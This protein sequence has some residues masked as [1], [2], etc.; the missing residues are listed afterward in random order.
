VASA[1]AGPVSRLTSLT[2]DTAA[3]VERRLARK[4]SDVELRQLKAMER[5]YS[6]ANGP[7]LLMFGES[8]MVW[9]VRDEADRRHLAE[10]IRDELGGNVKLQ[11][12]VGPGYNPRIIMAMLGALPKCTSEPKVVIVPMSLLMATT[13]WLA[14][15]VLGYERVAAEM[16]EVISHGGTR[17]KRLAKPSDEEWET[18]DHIPAPS[19]IGAR[20]TMGEVRLVTSA[21][22]QTRWQQAI[23]LRHLMDSYNAERLEPES[24][25]VGLV[26]HMATTIRD[27]GL[28]SVAY[29]PPVNL[30]VGDKVLGPNAREHILRNAQLLADSYAAAAGDSGSVVNAVDQCPVNEFA[31][32]LH[33]AEAG[34]RHVAHLIAEAI[35]TYL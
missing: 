35:K 34:R 30:D 33:L 8:N 29:I 10:M 11:G 31:D 27:M 5:A 28:K 4:Y 2:K 9:T 1:Q 24:L 25:G 26:A 16:T 6:S 14:H 15:P 21:V 18:F 12:M 19:L 17:P 32:P 22:P 20:R 3:R 13:H 23:R 7:E